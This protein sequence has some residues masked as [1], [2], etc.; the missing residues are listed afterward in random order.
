MRKLSLI[1]KRNWIVFLLFG[2]IYS[3]ESPNEKPSYFIK[4]QQLRQAALTNSKN[5][6][7]LEKSESIE[8]EQSR[9]PRRYKCVLIE[10]DTNDEYI[11]ESERSFI[12]TITFDNEEQ[13][14]KKMLAPSFAS[15]IKVLKLNEDNNIY[16]NNNLQYTTTIQ[17]TVKINTFSSKNNI[18]TN[19]LLPFTDS[20]NIN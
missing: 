9:K 15:E 8:N 13:T 6:F 5:Q 11:D 4:L 17:P 7:N 10:D 14:V 2:I 1:I 3:F 19:S 18:Q 12:K 20:V 16:N